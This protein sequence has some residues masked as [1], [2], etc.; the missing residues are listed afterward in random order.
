MA[1]KEEGALQSRRPH[2]NAM[3]EITEDWRHL[4]SME[5]AKDPWASCIMDGTVQ[6]D[7]YSIGNDLIIYRGRI[8][9]VT[10]SEMKGRI[11][12]AMHDSPMVEHPG[13]YRTYRQVREQFTWK[14]LKSDVLQYVREC[15]ICQ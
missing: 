14:G 15:P 4:I 11:L 6:D 10:G 3:I 5:Y 9:L 1:T 12:R 2:L 13:Y 7:R 8:F